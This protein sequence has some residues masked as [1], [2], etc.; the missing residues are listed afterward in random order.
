MS[1]DRGAKLEIILTLAKE[2]GMPIMATGAALSSMAAERI[3]R[4]LADIPG[5]EDK[6]LTN[7]LLFDPEL[8]RDPPIEY[9]VWRRD[10]KRR[11]WRE[12]MNVLD[13]MEADVDPLPDNE[14]DAIS[15]LI[16]RELKELPERQILV[17]VENRQRV[18]DLAD[19]IARQLRGPESAIGKSLSLI[20]GDDDE[21]PL[22]DLWLGGTLPSPVDM[23][24][25]LSCRVG[26]HTRD[27]PS[28]DLERIEDAFRSGR[29]RVL[30]A[31]TTVEAG[32]N[33]PVDTVVQIGLLDHDGRKLSQRALEQRLGRSGRTIAGKNQ[34]GKGIIYVHD[35]KQLIERVIKER[36]LK[37]DESFESKL[38]ESYRALLLLAYVGSSSD[39]TDENLE[40]VLGQSYWAFGRRP[41]EIKSATHSAI[42]NL[43]QAKLIESDLAPEGEAALRV[44]SAT[45]LG[46]AL[47]AALLL[48]GDAKAIEEIVRV[49]EESK[50]DESWLPEVLFAACKVPSQLNVS[51]RPRED[52]VVSKP[53]MT[54]KAVVKSWVKREHESAI[55]SFGFPRK[56]SRMFGRQALGETLQR[57]FDGRPRPLEDR[58]I[59]RA[60]ICWLWMRGESLDV[61]AC[62]KG[63]N[64]HVV[65][66][67]LAYY[68]S[69]VLRAASWL[70]Q[71]DGKFVVG[72]RL[73]ELAREVEFGV[74]RAAVTFFETCKDH[75]S[76]QAVS[77]VDDYD[78]R[79]LLASLD[80]RVA[81]DLSRRL[82]V[83]RERRHSHDLSS[84]LACGAVDNEDE[85]IRFDR[86]ENAK[87]VLDRLSKVWDSDAGELQ[88]VDGRTL[89]AGPCLIHVI[90]SESE[91]SS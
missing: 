47:S 25:I 37:Q 75:I 3:A 71:Y 16:V 55:Y 28:N 40:K 77:L 1:E 18:V 7:V 82:E 78:Y 88:L 41:D 79:K 85:R 19:N 87:D 76:R 68:T 33:L 6:Q 50:P 15:D 26:V 32:I 46:Q 43:R 63:L 89:R 73:R 58:A 59:I 4:W 13:T 51:R 53:P 17:F 22:S 5:K 10:G 74:P 31:T 27:V 34:S 64:E 62:I 67:D 39:K 60:Y 20:A 44:W 81:D 2:T 70:A 12:G 45:P 72:L 84:A 23:K 91:A 66:Q 52:D 35:S 21:A 56:K 90:S 38:D 61:K 11:F 80:A 83:R 14:E 24:S 54:Q 86:M 57:I 49:A 36:I 9:W 30:C 69:H 8:R 65:Q 42:A 48:P 29:L